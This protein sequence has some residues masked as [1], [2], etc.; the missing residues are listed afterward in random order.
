[1]HIVR[2]NKAGNECQQWELK[3][4]SVLAEDKEPCPYRDG[5]LR[6]WILEDLRRC[7][8]VPAPH[9]V[10]WNKKDKGNK[11]RYHTCNR[12][13]MDWVYMP[14]KGFPIDRKGLRVCTSQQRADP[15]S[16]RQRVTDWASE[17]PRAHRSRLKSVC[18]WHV[19]TK[20]AGKSWARPIGTVA[21]RLPFG[22]GPLKVWPSSSTVF[23]KRQ[24]AHGSTIY[25]RDKK[26]HDQ[27]EAGS[28]NEN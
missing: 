5:W 8:L 13:R 25:N 14:G 20:R 24:R 21:R 1:M 9:Q 27:Q 16:K 3:A 18:L 4:F 7:P 15:P 22:T 11:W 6:A 26:L 17:Q 10:L 12:N 23:N 28:I 2:Q 19:D